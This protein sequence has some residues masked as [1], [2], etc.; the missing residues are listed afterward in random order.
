MRTLG[1]ARMRHAAAVT[2][3]GMRAQ[4]VSDNQWMRAPAERKW[5]A[6]EITTHLTLTLQAFDTELRG[7]PPMKMRVSGFK[8]VLARMVYMQRILWNGRFPTGAPA[9]RETRPPEK[10]SPR[11]EC[12]RR[13]Q[14]MAAELEKSIEKV[15]AERPNVQVTHPYFGKVGLTDAVLISARHIEHHMKQLPARD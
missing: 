8:R 10:L 6:A 12:L 7:G 2:A 14:E 15:N 5:S 4:E 3:F 11:P 1:D 13:F 9:P